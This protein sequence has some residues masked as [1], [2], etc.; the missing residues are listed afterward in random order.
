MKPEDLAKPNTEHSHQV[1]VFCWATYQYEKWPELKWMFAVPNGGERNPAVAARLRAEGVKGGV[2]DICL[3]VAKC[4][5][6]GLFIEMK[7][8]GGRE[9]KDQKDFGAFLKE[10]GYFYRC[11]VGWEEARDTISDYMNGV[12]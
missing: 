8:P 4:G 1:A 9:S 7:K 6:H 3:P 11:C 5:Y 2:S 10:Q 12:I